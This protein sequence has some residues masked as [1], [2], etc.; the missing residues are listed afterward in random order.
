MLQKSKVFLLK[1]LNDQGQ[2]QLKMTNLVGLYIW[3]HDKKFGFVHIKNNI[4]ENL[5]G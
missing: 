4:Y 3:V 2:D 5:L 1:I